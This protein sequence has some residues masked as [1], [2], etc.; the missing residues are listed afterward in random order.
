[1]DVYIENRLDEPVHVAVVR[2]SRTSLCF[3]IAPSFVT[4]PS[5]EVLERHDVDPEHAL[6]L[7]GIDDDIYCS[8]SIE[9]WPDGLQA[10]M[11]EANG[12]KGAIYRLVLLRRSA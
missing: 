3:V 11:I 8:A 10:Q 7:P 9:G 12:E 1:M 2:H 6:S 4:V 5:G